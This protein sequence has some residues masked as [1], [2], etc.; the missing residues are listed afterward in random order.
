MSGD[1]PPTPEINPSDLPDLPKGSKIERVF[2]Q[3]EMMA[4]HKGDGGINFSTLNSEQK[5]KVL[6][7]MKLNESHAF[8]YHKQ[9]LQNDKEIKLAKINASIFTHKTSRYAGVLI[10]IV[11]AIITTAVLIYKDTFFIT[12]ITFLSGLIG[13]SLGGYGFGKISKSTDKE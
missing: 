1:E 9:K 12:W 13:G 2:E 7:V 8:E 5:D 11:L 4:L 6:D 10:I 3:V